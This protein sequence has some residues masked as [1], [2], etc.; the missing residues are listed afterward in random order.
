MQSTYAEYFSLLYHSSD[1][2]TVNEVG[3]GLTGLPEF[4]FLEYSL[5]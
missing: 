1:G 4:F 5:D 2:R 3:D